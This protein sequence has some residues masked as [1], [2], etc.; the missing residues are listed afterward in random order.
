MG[1]NA[2]ETIFVFRPSFQSPWNVMS[3]S[4]QRDGSLSTEADL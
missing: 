1:E 4:E 2:E 3:S